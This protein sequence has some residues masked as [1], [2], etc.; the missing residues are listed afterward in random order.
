M[1]AVVTESSGSAHPRDQLVRELSL[2]DASMLVVASVIGAGIFFTPG[3]VAQLLPAPGWIMAAW[4]VGGVLSLA[5]ALANAE[6]GAMYPRAGGDYVYLR[7][8]FHPIAG[9][10]VGWLTFFAIYAG[11]IAALAS[12]FAEGLGERFGWGSGGVLACALAVTAATSGINYVGVRWGARANNLTSVFKI[13]A[14]AAFAVLGPLSGAGDS[15]RLS[16]V[17]EPGAI[18]LVGFGQ[19]LSP[20]LFTYL[21]WNASIYVASEIRS[22]S[23]NVPRSLFFGLGIC[24]GIYLL[25][26]GVYLYALPME[27]LAG[28]GDAGTAAGLALFGEQAGTLVGIFVLVSILGTLNATVLV[29]PRIAYAMSLDGLFIG[30]AD[31]VHSSFRTPSTAIGIQG[32]VAIGLLLVLRSFPAAL[33]FTVF[34]IVLATVADVLALYRLR[35]KEPDRPRPYRAWGYPWVPGLYLVANLGIGVAMLV[36]S[37]VECLMGIGMLAAGL[38]FYAFFVAGRRPKGEYAQPQSDNPN[39]TMEPPG[40]D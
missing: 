19:A 37:P 18:T 13:L 21:G 11:T 10:L 15:A 29:G 4:A 39:T 2:L 6:L 36:G 27:S 26:N 9:F 5:G 40:D 1:L 30:G 20:V 12:A 14:L 31:R 28:V 38:P 7:E 24:A 34:A 33:G 17:A 23:R 16:E 3:Q 8:A 22:P 35:A 25:V 32:I